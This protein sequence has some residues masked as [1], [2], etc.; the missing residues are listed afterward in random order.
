[1]MRKQMTI[2]CFLLLLL[3]L[4][5]MVSSAQMTDDDLRIR[6][7]INEAVMGVYDSALDKDPNDY[8][9]RF[10][11]AN[12]LYY[13]GDYDKAIADAQ[14]VIS[15]IPNKEK[16][17]RF[18]SYLLLAT[19][20]DAKGEY[21][22]EIDALGKASE[23][24]PN[25]IPCIDMLAKVS[26]KVGDLEAAERNYAVIL[27]D[28][29]LSYDAMYG[30][31]KIEVKRSNYEKAASYVDRAVN[32]FTAEPQVYI[33]RS[34]VLMMMEQYEP[35][36]QDL[37]SALSVGSDSGNALSALVD[38]SDTHY[39]SVMDALANSYDKAPRVGTFYYVRAMI[40]MRHFHY[41]QAVKDLKT[42]IS[43]NLYDY[44]SVY[45]N[46]ALCQLELTQWDDALVNIN[47]AIALA[48]DEL[49]YYVLKAS[50]VQNNGKGGNYNEAL[51]VL[52][53]A[54]AKNSNCFDALLAK[55][56]VLLAQRKD[57]DALSC[58]NMAL[59][60]L[61]NHAEALLLRAWIYKYRLNDPTLAKVDFEKV[62][63]FDDDL[64]HLKGFALHELG[65]DEEARAWAKH[66]IQE[67]ILPGGETYF[68][69]SALHSDIGENEMGDKAI[70]LDYLRSALA[71]G[72]GSL[73][74]MKVNENPYVNMKLVRRYPEFNTILEQNETNFQERR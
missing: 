66:V 42:I 45:Y 70:S 68:Y 40:A 22:N 57:N 21:Q 12:Q 14:Q 32:L 47:K 2:K 69:A 73:Y 24:N 72:Y 3:A 53:Q 41:G 34:D 15:A 13:N 67:G 39:E 19:L 4:I 30:M 43:N 37:I 28:N 38:M 46:A 71:N 56:R 36:A 35:A 65:R 7:R 6:N 48:P 25:S 51:E 74:E 50:I 5:P 60:G 20:Y 17:L 16:E 10:A 23:I 18:D 33:N 62:A 9:T 64:A 49:E 1:M 27:R 59:N 52:N 29:P 58:V 55:A 44:H 31:A 8:Y 26:Y 63:S 61:H 11:R 54:L